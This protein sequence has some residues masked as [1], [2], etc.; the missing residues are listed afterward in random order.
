MKARKWASA[1]RLAEKQGHIY[2][3]RGFLEL[4]SLGLAG[5][6]GA[7]WSTDVPQPPQVSLFRE[8][9]EA[10]GLKFRHFNGAIGQY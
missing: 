1:G 2:T 4:L 9:A 10:V 7:P 3:R 5:G 6:I 8:V